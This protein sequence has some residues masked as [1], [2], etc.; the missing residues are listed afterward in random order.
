MTYE[1]A[2][3]AADANEVKRWLAARAG[4]PDGEYELRLDPDGRVTV[5]ERRS[6]PYLSKVA[7]SR[8]SV[9]GA[10]DVDAPEPSGEFREALPYVVVEEDTPYK[11]SARG[12]RA[13]QC[14]AAHLSQY[15]KRQLCMITLTVKCPLPEYAC[16]F[17][18]AHCKA[19][20]RFN[21][22]V[23]RRIRQRIRETF[24]RSANLDRNVYDEFEAAGWSTEYQKSGNH[25]SHIVRFQRLTEWGNLM[26]T[27]EELNQW[28]DKAFMAELGRIDREAFQWI[29]GFQKRTNAHVETVKKDVVSYVMKYAYKE[30]VIPAGS[31]KIKQA[32]GVTDAARRVRESKTI[33]CLFSWPKVGI[34]SLAEGLALCGKQGKVFIAKSAD[35]VSRAGLFDVALEVIP[36]FL[37][38]IYEVFGSRLVLRPRA[39]PT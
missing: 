36:L 11:I 33:S 13:L 6:T 28:W 18:L 2:D 26:Y 24:S 4:G 1:S 37:A 5:W 7:I 39:G 38:R 22:K 20:A 10:V 3:T 29:S 9:D 25:H 15:A 30:G 21:Q 16:S 27:F 12:K 35:G 19:L 14:L 31:C 34:A 23:A 17:A 32:W 8:A